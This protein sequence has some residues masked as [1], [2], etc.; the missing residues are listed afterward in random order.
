MPKASDSSRAGTPLAFSLAEFPSLPFS[1]HAA[2]PAAE[3][4]ARTRR[5]TG[6]IVWATASTMRQKQQSNVG[7]KAAS[8][9]PVHE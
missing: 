5:R 3:A 4:T 1:A 2:S 7:A 8:Y 6:R 9:H